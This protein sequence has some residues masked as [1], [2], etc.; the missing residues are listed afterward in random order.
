MPQNVG[1]PTNIGT[2]NH[3]R[4]FQAR[5]VLHCLSHA[6]LTPSVAHAFSTVLSIGSF[7]RHLLL[8][9]KAVT[10]CVSSGTEQ[11]ILIKC[12]T[13]LCPEISAH[14]H[15]HKSGFCVVRNLAWKGYHSLASHSQAVGNLERNA[16]CDGNH[17]W[18]TESSKDVGKI[19]ER[20]QYFSLIWIIELF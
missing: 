10:P 11:T 4:T 14:F 5:S 7:S 18:N 13:V 12:H 9:G 20:K 6:V 17:Q 15:R 1:T 8:S 3:W 19:W 16:I 2:S